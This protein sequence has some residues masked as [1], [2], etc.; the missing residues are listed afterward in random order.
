MSANNHREVIRLLAESSDLDF[1]QIVYRIAIGNPKAVVDA[2][3][4]KERNSKPNQVDLESRCA[5]LIKSFKKINAIK[6]WRDETVTTLKEAKDAVER[7][8]RNHQNGATT[9]N[10]PQVE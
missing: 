8:E 6:L 3:S 4:G 2:I 5:D 9:P 10:T 7:I 1:P